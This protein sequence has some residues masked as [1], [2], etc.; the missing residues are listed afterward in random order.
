MTT[1]DSNLWGG[2]SGRIY[3]F[4][5]RP[6][7]TT[8]V[9]A[10]VIRDGKNLKGRAL[11]LVLGTVG[12]GVLEKAFRNTVKAIEDRNRHDVKGSIQIRA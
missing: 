1:T 7:G 3:N 2:R 10:V 8:D 11:G 9:D 12:K 5:R 6:D 4:T